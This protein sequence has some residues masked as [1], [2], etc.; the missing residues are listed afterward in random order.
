MDATTIMAQALA[1]I[2]AAVPASIPYAFTGVAFEPEFNPVTGQPVM[3]VNADGTPVLNTNG[4]QRQATR[5]VFGCKWED[6]VQAKC[7]VATVAEIPAAIAHLNAVLESDGSG[8]RAVLRN[9]DKSVWVKESD[10][11]IALTVVL[12]NAR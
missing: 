9:G 2:N 1:A 5:Q 10:G 3:A 8:R 7:K 11:S 6:A 4:K 12:S